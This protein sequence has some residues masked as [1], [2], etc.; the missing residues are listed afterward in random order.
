MVVDVVYAVSFSILLLHTDAH[1]KNVRQ[2][3][4]KDTFIMRTKIIEGGE[5]VAQEILD[6]NIYYLIHVFIYLAK[7]SLLYRSCMTTLSC[8]NL[9][10][11]TATRNRSEERNVPMAGSPS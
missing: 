7:P 6:V 9:P 5:G 8:Q 11:Q 10:M 1:N 4:N 3:M 2:K